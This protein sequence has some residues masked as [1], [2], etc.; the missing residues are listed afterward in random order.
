[1][2]DITIGTK[3]N[4]WTIIGPP[5]ILN[6]RK[7]YQCRCDCG[8]EQP[9]RA[10]NLKSAHSQSHRGCTL[11][12]ITIDSENYKE[13][14]WK[15]KADPNRDKSE[16]KMKNSYVGCFFGDW[17]AIDIAKTNIYGDVYYL[18]V[19]SK[20]GATWTVRHNGLVDKYGFPDGKHNVFKNPVLDPNA[21]LAKQY[22]GSFGEQVIKQYLEKNNITYEREYI[23]PELKGEKGNLRFDFMV[24]WF[25]KP[26]LIEFQGV[27]H[28]KPVDF[29]GGT[30][31]FILQQ[32]YDELKRMYCKMHNY[33]LIE[34]PYTD[35]N[36]I[37]KHLSFLTI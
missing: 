18:C 31:R 11:K 22:D 21:P 5:I 23:F 8:H 34:I 20:T 16:I 7:H 25:H 29:F 30:E 15:Y 32:K 36:N 6:K 24:N 4:R 9:V 2:A 12:K 10:D 1:M 35:I 14:D 3:I 27:Q 19:H 33:V 26:V 17:L 13:K 28:Y 37:E